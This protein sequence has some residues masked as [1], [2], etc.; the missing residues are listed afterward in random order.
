MSDVN[1]GGA[2]F[3]QCGVFDGTRNEVNPVGA[4]F[5]AGGMSLRDWFAGQADVSGYK[6]TPEMLEQF[7][8]TKYPGVENVE[9]LIQFGLDAESKLRYMMA[10][11]MLKARAE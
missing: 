8:G 2:A 4:Y 7:I 11:A 10:D 9:K 6:L 5:D 3:P 1:D